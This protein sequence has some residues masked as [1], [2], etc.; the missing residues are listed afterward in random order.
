MDASRV[1]AHCFHTI[2]RMIGV[3]DRT[4]QMHDLN[5]LAVY[6]AYAPLYLL[7]P[8]FLKAALNVGFRSIDT[9][10][11][12]GDL[13]GVA[14]GISESAV[15]RSEIFLTTK[16]PGC[17]VPT[18]G[19]NPPCYSNTLKMATADINTLNAHAPASNYVDLLLLHFPP[20]EGCGAKQCPKIQQQWTALEQ[21]YKANITRAIGVS[22]FCQASAQPTINQRLYGHSHGSAASSL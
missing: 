12:Y 11:D 22:N 18:Q 2:I 1:E 17:G 16:V 6:F 21:L 9:A 14:S 4:L 3:P 13:H 15:P 8:L 5:H 10:H 7:S 20:L 19:L